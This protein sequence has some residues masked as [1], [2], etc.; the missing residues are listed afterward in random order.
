MFL[1]LEVQLC[2]VHLHRVLLKE[3]K[4]KHKKE[5][6]DDFKEVFRTDDRNDSKEDGMNR[7]LVAFR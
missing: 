5:L 4:P 1:N 2:V 3:V 7:F 6:S